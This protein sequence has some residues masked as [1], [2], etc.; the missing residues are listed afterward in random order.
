[1]FSWY[2]FW[3]NLLFKLWFSLISCCLKTGLEPCP[4][5][6]WWFLICPPEIVRIILVIA[7]IFPQYQEIIPHFLIWLS[8]LWH[9]PEEDYGLYQQTRPEQKIA[10]SISNFFQTWH[11]CWQ[12]HISNGHLFH[13]LRYLKISNINLRK[14]NEGIYNKNNPC[15]QKSFVDIICDMK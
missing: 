8:H 7:L 13:I 15:F 5:T 10:V 3:S 14:I 1:M 2:N 11:R 6:I 4:G 9:T 12:P